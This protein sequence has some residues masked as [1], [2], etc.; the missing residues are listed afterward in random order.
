M[1]LGLRLLV[2][3]WLVLLRPIALDLFGPPLEL[4]LDRPFTVVVDQLQ[5]S[6]QHLAADFNG[7]RIGPQ[8][9]RL[10]RPFVLLGKLNGRPSLTS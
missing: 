10:D 2:V 8:R 3:L 6:P 9:L 7:I 5:L 4:G 1:E